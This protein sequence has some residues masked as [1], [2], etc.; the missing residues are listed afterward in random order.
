MKVQEITFMCKT[1]MLDKLTLIGQFKIL[2]GLVVE[3][4]G[5]AIFFYH[6][7]QSLKEHEEKTESFFK[8][9]E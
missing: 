1:K 3:E 6:F 9:T 4:N 7:W 8:K 5:F 2:I